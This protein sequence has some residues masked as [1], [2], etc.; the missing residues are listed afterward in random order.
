[1]NIGENYESFFTHGGIDLQ[2]EFFFQYFISEIKHLVHSKGG[3]IFNVKC[4]LTL[5][6]P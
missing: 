6:S 2:I 3:I 5:N 1:M 4:Y